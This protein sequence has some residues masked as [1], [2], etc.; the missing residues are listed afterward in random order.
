MS[1]TETTERRLPSASNLEIPAGYSYEAHPLAALM[2]MMDEDAFAQHKADIGKHGVRE[3]ITLYQGMILDGRNRYKAAK[4]LGV[5]LTAKNFKEFTGTTTE[6]E[7]FVLSTNLHRR[8]L[9][10]KQKQEFAQKMIAKYPNESDRALARLTSLSK[11]TIAAAREA[12]ANSPEKRKFDSAVK[13]WDGLTDQQ[14]VD[15]VLMFQRD[16]RDIFT[17][18][19]VELTG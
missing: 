5:M 3:A 19:A 1:H 11:T 17:T 14:Q 12:L 15:F 6:A 16:I 9:N 2:P 7:A 13:A 10:N 8:Q 18:E 4:E